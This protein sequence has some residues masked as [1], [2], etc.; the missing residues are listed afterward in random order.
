ME[1]V[2]DKITCVAGKTTPR[3]P[4]GEQR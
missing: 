4:I 1:K 2:N 3:V